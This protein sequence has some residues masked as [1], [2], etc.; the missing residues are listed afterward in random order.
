MAHHEAL[1]GQGPPGIKD[2]QAALGLGLP[3]GVIGLE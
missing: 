2:R 1:H 3:E